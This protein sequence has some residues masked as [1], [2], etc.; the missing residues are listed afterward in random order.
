M[1]LE[2]SLALTL[3]FLAL[4]TVVLWTS[5]KVWYRKENRAKKAAILRQRTEEYRRLADPNDPML[6]ENAKKV[7]WAKPLDDIRRLLQTE[8]SWILR[9]AF[10]LRHANEFSWNLFGTDREEIIT[11]HLLAEISI[12]LRLGNEYV[13][14]E[15]QRLR[16]KADKP[17]S[18]RGEL[19][20]ALMELDHRRIAMEKT[21]KLCMKFYADFVFNKNSKRQKG[22]K[23]LTVFKALAKEVEQFLKSG[24]SF[25]ALRKDVETSSRIIRKDVTSGPEIVDL[26]GGVK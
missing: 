22:T 17:S 15:I 25:E 14:W 9:K 21:T 18:S 12:K 24:E 13:E 11:T 6:Q 1:P 8:R 2:K 7:R 16:E 4:L 19:K 5:R 10:S 3:L 20:V 23:D 26:S